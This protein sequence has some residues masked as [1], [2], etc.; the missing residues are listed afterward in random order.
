MVVSMERGGR[1]APKELLEKAK[2]KMIVKGDNLRL[3]DEKRGE[4]ATFKRDSAKKPHAIDLV[5]KE[6]PK[7]DI[8]RKALGIYEVD[9]D[10]LKIAWKKDG[11]ERPSKFASTAGDRTT[12][13]L[14]LKREKSQKK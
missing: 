8:E 3:T 5:F 1:P 14:V 9:G 4:G 7:E 13:Y 12:E 2:L 10:N 11:G 6:G